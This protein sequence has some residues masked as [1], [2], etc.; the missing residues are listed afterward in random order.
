MRIILPP[1]FYMWISWIFISILYLLEPIQLMELRKV[2]VLFIFYVIFLSMISS[3]I[4]SKLYSDA[5]RENIVKDNNNDPITTFYIFSAAG[6][7]GLYYFFVFASQSVGGITN[8]IAI[9]ISNPLE[10]RGLSIDELGGIVQL[11]YFSWLSLG[12]GIVIILKN[13][14]KLFQKILIYSII[15]VD[16]TSNLL[17]IDRTRP[18]W[19]IVIAS[20]SIA[21][22]SK[23]P[24]KSLK[25]FVTTAPPLIAILFIGFSILTGKLSSAGVQETFS[26]YMLGGF[27]YLNYL[28][29]NIVEFDYYPVRTFYPISKILE[30]VTIVSDV[31]SQIL[32]FYS[33]PFLTNI[34]TFIEP[35]YSDGGFAFLIMGIPLV[36]F[37]IDWFGL[38]A[39]RAK[40][41]YGAFI[42]ANLVF[43]NL[44]SFFVAKFTSTPIY[45]FIFIFL[46]S[47]LMKRVSVSKKKSGQI[48]SPRL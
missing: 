8:Y 25:R 34:G 5:L 27:S 11:T 35:L 45:F 6:L 46:M 37:F 15:F 22:I 28:F 4:F 17:F 10:I 43:C 30:S 42:Y 23:N 13:R 1:S 38:F 29:A 24:K 36:I 18:A 32:Y 41:Y 40:S 33:V 7:I 39:L 47:E 9:L 20:I 3:L 48:L 2:T 19:L 44:L 21:L 16:F 31:P 14:V 26:E 12:L